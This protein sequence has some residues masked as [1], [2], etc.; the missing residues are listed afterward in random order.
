MHELI[1]VPRKQQQAKNDLPIHAV[2]ESTICLSRFI[3]VTRS[4][5]M[6]TLSTIYHPWTE[7]H[8]SSCSLALVS[9][10]LADPISEA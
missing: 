5:T 6:N 3:H 9:P 4:L 7:D 2:H 1:K 8:K 10:R